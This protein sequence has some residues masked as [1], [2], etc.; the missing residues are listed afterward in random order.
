MTAMSTS[1]L[2]YARAGG[3]S[4]DTRAPCRDGHAGHSLS[5][6]L[7]QRPHHSDVHLWRAALDVAPA[8]LAQLSGHLSA[9]E[10][11]RAAALRDP[12][13][14]D[15]FTAGRG[16]LRRL[17]GAYLDTEPR[18]LVLDSGLRGKPFLGPPF[19]A[20]GVRFNLSHSGP[21]L[22]VAVARHREL[23]VDVEVLPRSADPPTVGTR[24]FSA[25][26]QA[27]LRAA[28]E[29]GRAVAFVECWTRK[30]ALI[31][32]GGTGLSVSLS[33]ID[34]V[35]SHGV[36]GVADPSGRSSAD[37]WY[38]ASFRPAPDAVAALVVE[39]PEWTL[40]AAPPFDLPDLD[41]LTPDAI[42]FGRVG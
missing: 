38:V 24:V 14:R 12:Q 41:Y 3:R 36:A 19:D 25:A 2:R 40:P 22:V 42:D 30:E 27:Y 6:V 31:K 37:R 33:A 16:L 15:R 11:E 17:L 29:A 4:T 23:G 21:L 7:R 34:V 20:S 1:V 26:E 9:A 18:A 10:R 39:G 32:A 28:P 5:A 13:S 35:P 8:E